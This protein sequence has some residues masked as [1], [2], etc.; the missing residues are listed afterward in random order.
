[1]QVISMFC[2]LPVWEKHTRKQHSRLQ[3]RMEF[4]RFRTNVSPLAIH[5][6]IH[7]CIHTYIHTYLHTY[8]PT[9]IPTYIH[10]YIPTYLHTYIPTYL[11]TYIPTY[12]HTYIPTNTHIHTHT[13][14]HTHIIH[15]HV[16]PGGPET[17]L[18]KRTF[19]FKCCFRYSETH[20]C[21]S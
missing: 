21:M 6:Y 10:T 5:T 16:H 18:V 19:F 11:H 14:T 1:M 17:V 8:L 4:R 2:M 7:A 13:H 3:S 12:L 15:R 20:I 9:H